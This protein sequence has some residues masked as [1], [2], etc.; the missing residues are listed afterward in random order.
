MFAV[1]T[2]FCA[3]NFDLKMVNEA[4]WL[5]GAKGE[6]ARVAEAVATGAYTDGARPLIDLAASVTSTVQARSPRT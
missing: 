5:D 6:F 3:T 2:V 4:E 1:H